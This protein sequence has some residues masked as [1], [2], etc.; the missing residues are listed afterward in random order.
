MRLVDGIHLFYCSTFFVVENFKYA[1]IDVLL[2]IALLF[3]ITYML[4]I[5]YK[6]HYFENNEFSSQ[7]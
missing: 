7:K 6:V 1:S 4:Y 5:L 3:H 2:G